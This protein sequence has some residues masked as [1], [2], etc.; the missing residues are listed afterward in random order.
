ITVLPSGRSATVIGIDFA[1]QSLQW[2]VAPQS[3]SL[4]LSE[5]I[6]IARGDVIAATGTFGE[7]SQDLYAELCWLS[8]KPLREGS[9]VLIKHGSKTVQALIRAVIGKLDLDTFGYEAA[10]VLELNDIGTAQIRLSSALPIE[11]YALHRRTGAFLVI[12]P[13]DGNTLAAGLV[14]ENL[15]D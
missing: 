15:R 1:G 13:Q 2:A 7:V 6:D 8:S 14:K 11:T 12:D 5:E 9:K 10:S 3:V 4:R